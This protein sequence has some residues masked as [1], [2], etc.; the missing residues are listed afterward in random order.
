LKEPTANHV[1]KVRA[2]ALSNRFDAALAKLFAQPPCPD[3]VGRAGPNRT[4]DRER[5]VPADPSLDGF[6]LSASAVT[7]DLVQGR[8]GAITSDVRALV[9]R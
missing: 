4:G 1:L 8:I 5:A 2:L 7:F 3:A 9:V 6:S